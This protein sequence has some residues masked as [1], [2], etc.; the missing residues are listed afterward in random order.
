MEGHRGILGGHR[1]NVGGM[2]RRHW[3]GMR[4]VGGHRVHKGN[5]GG[6]QGAEG[7]VGVHRGDIRGTQGDIGVMQG[8]C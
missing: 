6:K 2:Q 5:I 7:Y 4:N 3:G 1:K 8:R